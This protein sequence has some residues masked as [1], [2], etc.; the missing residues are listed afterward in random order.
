MSS[1]KNRNARILQMI[2]EEVPLGAIAAKFKLSSTRI[3][4]I[5]DGKVGGRPSVAAKEIPHTSSSNGTQEKAPHRSAPPQIDPRVT[6]IYGRVEA[7]LEVYASRLGIPFT[8][9][10]DGVSGL[11]RDKARGQ[12]VGT[13]NRLPRV[14]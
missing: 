14:R 1:I 11:L 6:Y 4:Q 8:Q 2:K 12:V 5:R 9:L 13:G 7:Q 10:A 3:A